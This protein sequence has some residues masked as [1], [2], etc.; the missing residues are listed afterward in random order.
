[1]SPP[2]KN[3]RK[4][5]KTPGASGVNIVISAEDKA[6]DIYKKV[7]KSTGT[8]TSANEKFQKSIFNINE[9]TEKLEEK[10]KSLDVIFKGLNKTLLLAT[11]QSTLLAKSFFGLLTQIGRLAVSGAQALVTLY[12]ATER[13]IKISQSDTAAPFIEILN[14]QIQEAASETIF[15]GLQIEEEIQRIVKV[16]RTAAT[17]ISSLFN[18]ASNV[19]AVPLGANEF[20]E[21]T[22]AMREGM[23][24]FSQG[25]F[26][27]VSQI[28]FF[29]QGLDA[30][31]QI[32]S[33]GP[34]QMLI[35]QTVELREQLLA[36]QASLVGTSKILTGFGGE[37]SDPVDAIKSL[38]TPIT[39]AINKMRVESLDLVGVTSKELVPV[40]QVIAQNA[41]SIG[42]SLEDTK[43]LTLDFA[44]SLGTLGL[45]LYQARQEITSILTGQ[46]D[47]NSALAK[48]LNITNQMVNKWK[49][50]GILVEELRKRLEAFRAGNALAAK[51][52]NGVTS[53][54]QEVFDLIAQKAGE[55]LLD[56][57]VRELN[58]LYDFLG[59]NQEVLGDYLSGIVEQLY[60][61]GESLSNILKTLIT[62]EII[63]ISRNLGNYLFTSIKN[64]FVALE[65]A[66]K[67]VMP[68]LESVLK[69]LA[70]ISGQILAMSD[71]FLPI[72]LS[73]KG[74]EIGILGAGKA[75]GILTKMLPGVGELLFLLDNNANSLINTF[76]NLSGVV[77]EGAS[78][79]L[80]F[81]QNIEKVPGA[82]QAVNNAIGPLGPVVTQFLPTIG[83]LGVTMVGIVKLVPGLKGFIF[84]LFSLTPAL[85]ASTKAMVNANLQGTIFA[86]LLPSLNAG[87]S[88]LAPIVDTFADATARSAAINRIAATTLAK[89]RAEVIGTITRL[90]MLTIGAYLAFK[91]FDEFV[92]KNK[93]LL[94]I[95]GAVA[96]GVKVLISEISLAVKAIIDFISNNLVVGL[97]LATA[98]VIALSIATRGKLLAALVDLSLFLAG[99]AI[100][101]VV[102]FGAALGRV[103]AILETFGIVNL[104]SRLKRVAQLTSLLSSGFAQLTTAIKAFNIQQIITATTTGGFTAGLTALKVQILGL[105]TATLAVLKPLALLAAKIAV[106]LAPLALLAAGI[107]AIA[108][109]R[110]TKN[111]KE[112]TEALEEYRK[113]TDALT[114]SALKVQMDLIKAKK[115]QAEADRTGIAL[116]EEQYQNNKRIIRQAKLQTE[117]MKAR[118]DELSKLAEAERNKDIKEG[119]KAQIAELDLFIGKLGEASLIQIKPK[120]LPELGNTLEQIQNK[121]DSAWRAILEP[122]GDPEIFKAKAGEVIELN[123][124]LL[125]MG[126]VVEGEVLEK[127][128]LL[129]NDRRLDK[130][131]QIKAQ[132]A[133]TQSI[134]NEADRQVAIINT[135]SEAIKSLVTDG[136][137]SEIQGEREVTELTLK[138]LDLRLDAVKRQQEEIENIVDE[139]GQVI[140]PNEVEKKQQEILK[141]E[142]EIVAKRKELRDKEKENTLSTFEDLI[143]IQEG[144]LVKGQQKESIFLNQS[145]QL[146]LAQKEKEIE[147]TRRSLAKLES[148]DTDGRR[149]L[150][151]EIGKLQ[152]ERLQIIK[153][154]YSSEIEL[155]Q[156]NLDKSL[157]LV[158]ESEKQRQ[159]ERLRNF[160]EFGG[161]IVEQEE[162][163]IKDRI[164]TQEQEIINSQKV[165]AKLES[166][167]PFS[168]PRLEADRQD[169]IREARKT[170]SDNTISLL[171]SETE[172]WNKQTDVII[173]GLKKE[174]D[175]SIAN[176]ESQTRAGEILRSRISLIESSNEIVFLEQQLEREKDVNK[177][178]ELSLQLEKARTAEVEARKQVILDEF[179]LEQ[180]AFKSNLETQARA[181]ELLRSRIS[182]IES[183]NEIVVLEQQLEIE[184]DLSKQAELN[185]QLEKAR[186]AEVEAKKQ[187]IL[188]EFELEQNTKLANVLQQVY[189]R[190]LLVQEAEKIQADTRVNQLQ[191]QIELST[192]KLE[193]TRLEKELVESIEQ[194]EIA[195]ERL[196][197]TKLQLSNLDELIDKTNQLNEGQILGAEKELL[198]AQQ[199]R[200]ELELQLEQEDDLVKLK[201]LQLELSNSDEEIRQKQVAVDL[202]KIEL[203]NIKE[204]AA[205]TISLNEGRV[206]QEELALQQEQDKL[207]VLYKQLE[208][209][210]DQE[211]TARLNLE[212]SQQS[213][214]VERAEEAL[215][216]GNLS[217]EQTR[218]VLELT[219]QLNSGVI[220]SGEL[221]VE[222]SKQ[223]LESLELQLELE[224][225]IA[226]VAELKLNIEQETRTLKEKELALTLQ[227]IDMQYRREIISIKDAAYKGLAFKEEVEVAKADAVLRRVELELAAET[228]IERRLEL[229]EQLV[230]ALNAKYEAQV[231]L[232]QREL[233]QELLR[234][235][236]QIKATNF[237]LD[238]QSTIYGRIN[239]AVSIQKDLLSA[240]QDVYQAS[241]DFYVGELEAIANG[242]KSERRKKEIA[243]VI[244]AI[245]LKGAV[246]QYKY[247]LLSLQ[248]QQQMQKL[249]LERER[250]SQRRAVSESVLEAKRTENAYKTT[251]LNRAST[252]E[253]KEAARLELQFAKEAVLN[254]VA[255]YEALQQQQEVQKQ[256][257][258]LQRQGLEFRGESQIRQAQVTAANAVVNRRDRRQAVK[259]IQGDA[260]SNFGGNFT[261]VRDFIGSGKRTALDIRNNL[262][263]GES[264]GS[265]YTEEDRLRNLVGEEG[266]GLRNRAGLENRRLLGTNYAGT[267]QAQIGQN[268]LELPNSNSIDFNKFKE[269][270]EN[271]S[272]GN[273]LILQGFDSSIKPILN[274]LSS[275]EKSI[276]IFAKNN[277]KPVQVSPNIT[278]NIT[279]KDGNI[280]NSIK[281]EA[282]PKLE[283]VIDALV[284][285]SRSN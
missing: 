62:P 96:N 167:S 238:K 91:A 181:G 260:I 156:R 152:A 52:L 111:I 85:L 108:L 121:A 113:Q 125:E 110:Y 18:M 169:Q 202:G 189:D 155:L 150:N 74:L 6:S 84:T 200:S 36:T 144:L 65:S 2:S 179:E 252:A 191:Q 80:V 205:T 141:I 246:E 139:E 16:V 44:A 17:E 134:Q 220:I 268:P 38:E 92:L 102:G 256:M 39:T 56:L 138:E 146:K 109:I 40:F 29:S 230:D 7:I 135:R 122:T 54:I 69:A 203:Q 187:V 174:Q 131:V 106:I 210:K 133:I 281:T 199:R 285:R 270:I 154:G 170:L 140:N 147:F 217:L 240:Q 115:L 120:D 153:E 13:L 241:T 218:E 64:V 128:R 182:L 41:T 33:T 273:S 279:G 269:N 88:R 278:F 68:Q 251:L 262:I 22:G 248:I 124:Q 201:Q 72:F 276:E 73:I 213:K 67:F 272:V 206:L 211:E 127:L 15:V 159:I 185:L 14:Q 184:K 21:I 259:Q 43:D 117:T 225:D 186:T 275:I 24:R 34:F 283:N 277:S 105:K 79:F 227:Q 161:S 177:Q 266:G 98:A 145:N 148:T 229:Q 49:D 267:N 168:D 47:M 142:T 166:Q 19:A 90:G 20:L 5:V 243:E 219:K 151:A 114:D 45:P 123:N 3:N 87:F 76:F 190:Q 28:G 8:V 48:N 58:N 162:A 234:A 244:A 94:E 97:S 233:N 93:Y 195:S 149:K 82:V 50:Q 60:E 254:Q 75:F 239:K 194:A 271:P 255:G 226:K 192:D 165:L 250:I 132:Q 30:I 107:G 89:V 171:N 180:N 198:V 81:A 143:S 188:D 100:N 235:T 53:N 236:N 193:K 163:N 37:F 242:E 237:E 274:P 223:K 35:N 212:I 99:Q 257:F 61:A 136:K 158:Q 215:M 176:M 59:S 164:K 129:A 118:R 1:M 258:D 247:E 249:E 245:R 42:A 208:V 228:K 263:G 25:M 70:A 55:P 183:S 95:L 83:T 78:G 77:G 207:E 172:A 31:T 157:D 222:Q 264:R 119:Y 26:Q 178:A 66:V 280:S 11:N 112:Q 173:S 12:D 282:L 9:T 103:A 27:V 104:A 197:L 32:A 57:L 10:V 175:A 130:E 284:A 160:Q 46:I 137:K 126:Q 23:E 216:L 116:T 232:V 4:N 63:E 196:D 101:S 231:A 221:E 253:E 209:S 214:V 265:G 224:E 261:N 71:I 204:L 51:T 86:P